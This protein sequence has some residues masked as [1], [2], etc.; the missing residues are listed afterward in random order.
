[1]ICPDC[2]GRGLV[3]DAP[4]RVLDGGTYWDTCPT[5]EGTGAVLEDVMAD[6]QED[7]G[8]Q[9]VAEDASVTQGEATTVPEPEAKPEETPGTEIV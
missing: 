5:C 7:G 4:G 1:M 6:E 8:E 3:L 2:E 9:R